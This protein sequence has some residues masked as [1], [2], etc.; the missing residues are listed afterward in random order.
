[1]DLD[2]L[3]RLRST[4]AFANLDDLLSQIRSD[5]E[6]ARQICEMENR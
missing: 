3:V 4:R 5:I 6:R 2:F 1:M